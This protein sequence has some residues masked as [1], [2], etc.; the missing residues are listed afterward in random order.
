LTELFDDDN[1][2]AAPAELI[3]PDD[4]TPFNE[5]INRAYFYSN[6]AQTA[7]IALKDPF[8]RRWPKFIKAEMGFAITIA[9]SARTEYTTEIGCSFRK[10]SN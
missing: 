3:L 8:F 5:L 2:T 9:K 10:T 1:L 7:I 6:T 4:E